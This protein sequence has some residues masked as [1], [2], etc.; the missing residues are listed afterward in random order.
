MDPNIASITKLIE[1]LSNWFG[2]VEQELRSNKEHLDR[3]ERETI[4]NVSEN[5]SRP[6]NCTPSYNVQP[7]QDGMNLRNIKLEASLLMVSWIPKIFSIGLRHGLL[8]WLA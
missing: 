7:D 6:K 2:N 8:F 3:L 4:E 5:E 1:D